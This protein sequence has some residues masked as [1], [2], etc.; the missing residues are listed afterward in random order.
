MMENRYGDGPAVVTLLPPH[1][2]YLRV[3][4][5]HSFMSRIIP[6]LAC[7]ILVPHLWALSDV[8]LPY[9]V[10]VT[11]RGQTCHH[12]SWPDCVQD[13]NARVKAKAWVSHQTLKTW[14]ANDVSAPRISDHAKFEPRSRV[15]GNL[16]LEGL[17][18]R[19]QRRKSRDAPAISTPTLPITGICT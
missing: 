11:S 6:G 8:C 4:V 2:G 13:A 19:P 5:C 7:G 9:T 10:S 18:K 14:E 3:M 16:G 15:S 1:Q 17:T 12:L